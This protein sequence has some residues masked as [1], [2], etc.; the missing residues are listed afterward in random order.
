MLGLNYGPAADPLAELADRRAGLISV[1]ARGDDYHDVI[2]KRL[3]ALGA[4]AR[5]GLGRRRSRSSST[6][7][8]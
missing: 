4:L 8:R 1:Y 5:R 3:K 2:K 7:R 6:P